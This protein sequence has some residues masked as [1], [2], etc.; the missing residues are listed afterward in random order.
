M[1]VCVLSRIRLSV[2]PWTIARQAPWSM[3]FSRH[4]YWSGLPFS[5]SDI[6]DYYKFIFYFF[7]NLN[8]RDLTLLS[9]HYSF[10]HNYKE[11]NIETYEGNNKL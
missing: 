5:S 2:T 11:Y 7:L 3:E 6:N 8:S 1:T 4:E 9:F 10:C